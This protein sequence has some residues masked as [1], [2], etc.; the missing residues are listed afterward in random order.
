MN[1]YVRRKGDRWYVVIYE[2][3]DP[4]TGRQ[5]SWRRLRVSATTVRG[6]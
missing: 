2:G 6:H 5:Q 1:G 4:A 3:I